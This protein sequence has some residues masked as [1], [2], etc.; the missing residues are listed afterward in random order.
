MLSSQRVVDSFT[1]MP[2]SHQTVL[3]DTGKLLTAHKRTKSLAESSDPG[4]PR[5][6]SYISSPAS[7]TG[8]SP[9]VSRLRSRT[10]STSVGCPLTPVSLVLR[11]EDDTRSPILSLPSPASPGSSRLSVSYLLSGSP[12]VP[13]GRSTSVSLSSSTPLSSETTDGGVDEAVFYGYDH[14]IRDT[15]INHTDDFRAISQMTTY[16][17]HDSAFP[18]GVQNEASWCF[19]LAHA[20][21]VGDGYYS[22]PVPI[23]IPHNLQPLPPKLRDNSMNL[24]YFVSKVMITM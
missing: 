14:G 17:S 11:P 3:D 13:H 2:S 8:S 7:L 19:E 5:Q 12:R 15:D 22:Q 4:G 9:P 10:S 1:S 20:T 21:S 6:H 23:W 16:V 24:L 18:N